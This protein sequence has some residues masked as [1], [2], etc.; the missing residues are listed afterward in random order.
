MKTSDIARLP[1]GSEKTT[2]EYTKNDITSY[3][4]LTTGSLCRDQALSGFVNTRSSATRCVRGWRGILEIYYY[5]SNQAS[6]R[7]INT[8]IVRIGRGVIKVSTLS[9]QEYE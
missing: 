9:N 6:T 7:N 8:R 2:K 1:L 5:L 3:K 4:A